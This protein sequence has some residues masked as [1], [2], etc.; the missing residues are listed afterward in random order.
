MKPKYLRQLT[1]QALCVRFETR[2]AVMD[3]VID[4]FAFYN[5]R[6]LHSTLGYV[7]LMKFEKEWLASQVTLT[8]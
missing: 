8:A 3:E 5:H 6:R 2:R 7:S 1:Q 4:W